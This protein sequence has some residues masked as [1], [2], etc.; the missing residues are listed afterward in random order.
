MGN[1]WSIAKKE[2]HAYSGSP[3]AYIAISIY[4]VLVG[5]TF[6]FKIP[7]LFPKENFFVAREAT[8][9]PLFQWTVVLFALI[10]PAVSMRLFA[11]EKRDGTLE[12]LLSLP[13]SDFQVV[14]GKYLGAL[15]FLAVGLGLSLVYAVLVFALGKP[16]I[17]PLIGGYF[18]VFLMGAGFLAIGLMASVWTRSQI[19]AFVT[20]LAISGFLL[21]ADRI[22]E[23]LG[24]GEVRLFNMLSFN[25][26]FESIARGVLDSRDIVFFFSVI[27]VAVELTRYTLESRKWR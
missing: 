9:R 23:L 27:V 26:H 18:G 17:G 15:V 5:V 10:L 13:V 12:M 19:V 14:M 6:F 7:F 1:I 11:E 25:Y 22:P 3:I 20:A 2:L 24:I 4:L 8:L 16:D 21:F